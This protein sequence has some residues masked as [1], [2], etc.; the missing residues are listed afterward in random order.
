MTS[1]IDD[2]KNRNRKLKL[3]FTYTEEK[4]KFYKIPTGSV[5]RI[6]NESY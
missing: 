1:K 3:Q 4:I 2:L 5:E 6:K